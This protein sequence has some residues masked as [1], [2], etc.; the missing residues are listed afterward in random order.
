MNTG[1]KKRKCPRQH[2][3][4]T[5]RGIVFVNIVQITETHIKSS[6]LPKEGL[7]VPWLDP[8]PTSNW[9]IERKEVV[10]EHREIELHFNNPSHLTTLTV[11]FT[12]SPDD[13]SRLR[14]MAPMPRS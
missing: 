9:L 7:N 12:Q 14:R 4:Q 6:P 8:S 13:P 1:K 5:S 3:A 11:H 2:E 10:V